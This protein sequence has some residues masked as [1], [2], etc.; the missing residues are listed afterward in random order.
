M[1]T[2]NLPFF[3][4]VLLE[5]GGDGRSTVDLKALQVLQRVRTNSQG[6]AELPARLARGIGANKL[7]AIIGTYR[8]KSRNSVKNRP[9]LPASVAISMV[10]GR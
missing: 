1:N 10:V 7:A 4:Q 8:Q 3:I 6:V 5:K 2:S 9:K